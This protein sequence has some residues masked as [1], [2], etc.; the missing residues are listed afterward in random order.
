MQ[1]TIQEIHTKVQTLIAQK[2]KLQEELLFWQHKAEEQASMLSTQKQTIKQLKT[3]K[4][5]LTLG[6]SMLG[7]ENAENKFET[8]RKINELVTEIDKC[9]E[10]LKTS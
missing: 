5:A 3:E 10:L 7:G 8:K 1:A 2:N 9:I 4:E 6:A